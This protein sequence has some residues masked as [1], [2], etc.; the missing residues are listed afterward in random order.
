MQGKSTFQ[1]GMPVFQGLSLALHFLDNALDQRA[2]PSTVDRKVV[3]RTG[4]DPRRL[5]RVAGLLTARWFGC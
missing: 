3:A 5:D 4:A 2:F 1:D